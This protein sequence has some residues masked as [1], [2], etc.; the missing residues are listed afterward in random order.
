MLSVWFPMNL[1]PLCVRCGYC[2]TFRSLKQLS[3]GFPIIEVC[4][5]SQQRLLQTSSK[6]P[7]QA[8]Q[9]SLAVDGWEPWEKKGRKILID[10]KNIIIDD[11]AAT[12]QAHRTANR[13]A[14]VRRVD[15]DAKHPS[16]DSERS[17]QQPTE[18]NGQPPPVAL[19]PLTM[20]QPLELLMNASGEDQHSLQNVN[21]SASTKMT[22]NASK[23][24]VKKTKEE[25]LYPWSVT[26][27][28]IQKRTERQEN[29]YRNL[30]FDYKAKL[31]TPQGCWKRNE[32]KPQE[33]ANGS[34]V[35]A[36]WLS[37]IKGTDG[38]GLARYL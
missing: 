5:T 21:T 23:R 36:P 38:S 24:P 27:P 34:L 1:G 17:D 32:M 26:S 28:Q 22:D 30:S 37:L 35:Y 3:N 14:V 16:L 4:T 20:N 9:S 8:Q 7:E 2:N 13:A 15:S 25:R 10:G 11:L 29:H 12:L 33:S 18:D 6:L 19:E 31:I